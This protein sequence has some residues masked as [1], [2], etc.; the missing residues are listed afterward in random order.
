MVGGVG[1]Q[2]FPWGRS[3]VDGGRVGKGESCIKATVCRL[4]NETQQQGFLSRLA[5]DVGGVSGR[6][7]SRQRGQR[8]G[9][10][11]QQATQRIENI[12]GMNSQG[13]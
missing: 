11:R 9:C 12:V 13:K 1:R 2:T 8:G 7:A 4:Q 3:G 10:N 6:V 5:T